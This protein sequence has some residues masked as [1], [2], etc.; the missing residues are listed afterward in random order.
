MIEVKKHFF[1]G[2]KFRKVFFSSVILSIITNNSIGTKHFLSV[3]SICDS[4]YFFNK[5]NHS[6]DF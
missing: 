4:T 6:D 3:S 2:V 5:V 1:D